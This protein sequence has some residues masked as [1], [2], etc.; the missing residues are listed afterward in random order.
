MAHHNARWH[1]SKKVRARADEWER[2]RFFIFYQS[3]SQRHAHRYTVMMKNLFFSADL[4]LVL[5]S[6]AFTVDFYDKTKEKCAE[7]SY[8]SFLLTTDMT[9]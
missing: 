8:L 7:F 3:S 2:Q 6:S 5:A 4:T 9:R 1:S